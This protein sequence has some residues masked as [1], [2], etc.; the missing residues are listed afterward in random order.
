MA[1][2]KVVDAIKT[3]SPSTINVPVRLDASALAKALQ[4]TQTQTEARVNAGELIK[5]SALKIEEMYARFESLKVLTNELNGKSFNDPVPPALKISEIVF[6]FQT[7]KDGVDSAMS[8]AV[9][10]N[11]ICVGDIANLLSGELG[12]IIGQ[13]EQEA[14]AVKNI[15]TLTEETSSKAKAAW[16]ANN[17]TRKFSTA[18][19]EATEQQ[20]DNAPSSV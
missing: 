15:A 14:A 19:S 6:K 20:S 4:S 10:K 8:E 13:L 12:S 11:V 7:V 5:N 2:P 18:E 17:P 9:V 1:Q 16:E 3:E